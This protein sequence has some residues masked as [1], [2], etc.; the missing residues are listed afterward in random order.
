MHVVN[1]SYFALM[2]IIFLEAVIKY[3]GVLVYRNSIDSYISGKN[4][5]T[6]DLD[7]Y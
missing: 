7:I 6:K 4:G 1:E 2:G 3:M 5:S